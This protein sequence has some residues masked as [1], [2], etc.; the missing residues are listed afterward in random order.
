MKT[1]IS[2]LIARD[3]LPVHT[4]PELH[5]QESVTDLPECNYLGGLT[6]LENKT[7]K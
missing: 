7:Q 2:T 1:N 3:K 4:I 6:H 5:E